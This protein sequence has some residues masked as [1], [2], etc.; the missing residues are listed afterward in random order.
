MTDNIIYLPFHFLIA[1]STF[2]FMKLR[3][4]IE[5]YINNLA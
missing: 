1:M 5:I 3:C 2:F 4:N